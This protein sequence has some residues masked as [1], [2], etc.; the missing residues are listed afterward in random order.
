MAF[1][2]LLF[3]NPT[4]LFFN[5]VFLDPFVFPPSLQLLFYSS[6]CWF[7]STIDLLS[8][9]PNAAFLKLDT[10]ANT[11]HCL[12]CFFHYR[13]LLLILFPSSC[14]TDPSIYYYYHYYYLFIII[15]III[16]II[17]DSLPLHPRNKL[18][19][20]HRYLLS[21]ISWDLTI[22]DI[23]MTWIKQTLDNKVSDYIRRWLEM[24]ISGTLD[25]ISLSKKKCGLGFV[26]VSGRFVQCQNTIRSCLKNSQN[27]DLRKIYEKTHTNTN[28]QY[29][30][31]NSTR[32]VIKNIRA[33]K[34]Q[35]IGNELTT[36]ALVVKSIWKHSNKASSVLWSK[37]IT[38]LPKNIYNFCIRYVNNTL[39]NNTNLHKWGKAPSPLCSACNK[40]QT[41]GH[42]VA[43]CSVHLNEKRY[44]YRHLVLLNIVKSIKNSEVRRIY[45]DLEGYISPSII[46]GEDKRP[47][48]IIVERDNVCIFEL[49]IGFETNISTN[50]ERKMNNYSQLLEDLK[51]RYKKVKFINLSMGAIGIYGDTCFNLKSVLK[52]WV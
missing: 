8:I 1:L 2:L 52:L 44:N 24:P 16:I 36:Q 22:A 46:S 28:L 43:G 32:E 34:E 47:D 12:R 39:A 40:P 7:P 35:H 48:I 26:N 42:V 18:L 14:S 30:Q 25:V 45:A 20:Y 41:L 4:L 17:I 15:I 50:S 6:P 13:I 51:S 31:F 19:I 33:G 49:S 37:V 3:V 9:Y 21:K 5:A 23:S 11:L 27:S 29:D 10:Y 38:Q